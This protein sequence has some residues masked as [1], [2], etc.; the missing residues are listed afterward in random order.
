MKYQNINLAW[1]QMTPD[2]S[3]QHFKNHMH[4]YKV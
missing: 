1:K 4:K 2:P 3:K